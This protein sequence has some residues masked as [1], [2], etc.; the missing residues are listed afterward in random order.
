MARLSPLSDEG[1]PWA[2]ATADLF[3]IAA[4]VLDDGDL[5]AERFDVALSALIGAI[6][7]QAHRFVPRGVSLVGT[8]LGGRVIVHTWPEREALTIDLYGAKADA[9]RT[10]DAG[11]ER[12]IQVESTDS[13]LQARCHEKV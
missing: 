13:A 12:F 3:G 8:A 7:W 10:L 6:V 4:R 9:E 11:V 1:G 2:L 5:L